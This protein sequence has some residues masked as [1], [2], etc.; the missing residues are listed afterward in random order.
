MSSV[1]EELGDLINSLLKD[2]DNGDLI[3]FFTELNEFMGQLSKKCFE[4]ISEEWMSNPIVHDIFVKT[5][6]GL[7]AQQQASIVV[8]FGQDSLD[9]FCQNV[10]ETSAK[11]QVSALMSAFD[12]AFE[13]WRTDFEEENKKSMGEAAYKARKQGARAFVLD[14]KNSMAEDHEVAQGFSFASFTKQ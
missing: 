7:V 10:F 8:A 4:F 11:D 12:F 1:S 14:V 2:D 3:K 9:E 5:L 13:K 6:M